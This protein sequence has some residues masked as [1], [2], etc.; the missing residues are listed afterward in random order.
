MTQLE[1]S[2]KI[3]IL[4]IIDF[5][6]TLSGGTENQ[7]VKILNNLDKKKYKLYLLTLKKTQW[8]SKNKSK[9]ECNVKSFNIIKLKNPLNVLK[10]ILVWL[11]IKKLKPDIVMTFFPLSNILGVFMAKLA[12]I[13][14]IISTRRDYGLWLE[15]KGVSLLRVANI[16]VKRIVANSNKVKELTARKELFDSSKIDVIYN[17]IDEASL[18]QCKA[19]NKDSWKRKLR[20]PEN[21]YVLG[22]VAGLKPMKKHTTIIKSLRQV[23][24]VRSDVHLVIVGDGPLRGEF[25]ALITELGIGDHVHFAGSQE[26]VSPFL[27][28]FDIGINSSANEGLSNAIMEYMAYGVPCIV[29]N[30]GG[31][32]EL[33]ENGTN[34][35]TF[36]LDNFTEL[37]ERIIN[38][39][40]DEQK[41]KKFASNAKR[42]ILDQLTMSKMIKEYDKAFT[43]M[44]KTII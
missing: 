15:K 23:L 24:N 18:Q 22:T 19:F 29:S 16:F 7:L 20:I 33:I 6:Y 13:R 35:Y 36:E 40:N 11:Y 32:P 31:N 9:L 4:F 39:L 5:I 34:G 8:V 41:R 12:S 25:E 1:H 27:S 10:F 26:D 28:I 2:K 38:L 3:R 14:N 42:K 44:L 37:A 21:V 17:G 30:A 43:R